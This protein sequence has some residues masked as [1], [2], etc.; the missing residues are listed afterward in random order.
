MTSKYTIE[1]VNYLCENNTVIHFHKSQLFYKKSIFCLKIC[2][3]RLIKKIL[4][5]FT[6]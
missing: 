5:R 4:L 1:S 3:H 6:I 2:I